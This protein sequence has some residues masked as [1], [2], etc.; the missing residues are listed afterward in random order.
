MPG[1]LSLP[2]NELAEHVRIVHQLSLQN[3]RDLIAFGHDVVRDQAFCLSLIQR[4]FHLRY[5]G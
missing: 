2:A 1:S 3:R 4:A 5:I